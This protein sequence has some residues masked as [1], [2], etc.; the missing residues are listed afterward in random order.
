MREPLTLELHGQHRGASVF[1]RWPPDFLFLSPGAQD[2]TFI[3]GE[4]ISDSGS[5]SI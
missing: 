3:S 5:V 4:L 1:V 2:R